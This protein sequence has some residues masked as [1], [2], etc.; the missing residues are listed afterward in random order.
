MGA[1]ACTAARGDI[2][3]LLDLVETLLKGEVFMA[4]DE[5]EIFLRENPS[6]CD[7]NATSPTTTNT[8]IL[9]PIIAK[10]YCEP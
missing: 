7:R 8:D 2:W 5:V 6:V 4:E 10:S 9:I 3:R 1:M